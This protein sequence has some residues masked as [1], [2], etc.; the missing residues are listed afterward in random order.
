MPASLVDAVALHA[1]PL[2]TNEGLETMTLVAAADRLLHA[3]DA[4]SGVARAEVLDELGH[5]LPGL[6]EGDA[7]REIWAALFHER[8]RLADVFD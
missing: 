7:W 6:V 3:T 2:A 4:T 5:A 1:D 8:Q